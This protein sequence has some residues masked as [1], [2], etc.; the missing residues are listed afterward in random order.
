VSPLAVACV[1]VGLP[2]LYVGL[3][4]L[5]TPRPKVVERAIP[6]ACGCGRQVHRK[7]FESWTC[8]FCGRWNDRNRDLDAHIFVD[9]ERAA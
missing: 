4:L 9:D 5:L 7:A 6:D 1:A 2:L 3:R 8:V